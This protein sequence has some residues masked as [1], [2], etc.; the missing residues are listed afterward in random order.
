MSIS[1]STE[2]DYQSETFEV[3]KKVTKR[4]QPL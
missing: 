4:L 3:N 1:L 2:K